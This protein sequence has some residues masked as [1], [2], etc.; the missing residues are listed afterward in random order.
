MVNKVLGRKDSLKGVVI[1]IISCTFPLRNQCF[2]VYS[3]NYLFA[4][5]SRGI[6]GNK[7]LA[8]RSDSISKRIW[9][10]RESNVPLQVCTKSA[11]FVYASPIPRPHYRKAR[12]KF[13]NISEVPVE[14]FFS[15]SENDCFSIEPQM[16]YIDVRYIPRYSTFTRVTFKYPSSFNRSN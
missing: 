12:L 6:N 16:L 1:I 2:Y 7:L 5:S 13:C 10:R 4:L 15:L 9:N 11:S 3:G 14:V 8:E